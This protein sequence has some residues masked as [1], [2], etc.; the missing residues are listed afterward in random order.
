MIRVNKNIYVKWNGFGN[1]WT[2]GVTACQQLV[3]HITMEQ[4]EEEDYNEDDFIL[5]NKITFGFW[6]FDIILYYS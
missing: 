4:L 3:A 2:L 1:Y 6:L 5:T